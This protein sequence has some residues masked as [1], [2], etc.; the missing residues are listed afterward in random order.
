MPRVVAV[1]TR[2]MMEKH[3]LKVNHVVSVEDAIDILDK[4][5]VEGRIGADIIL[6]DVYLKGGMTG[7]EQAVVGEQVGE[8]V[9]GQWG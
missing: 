8:V 3:G 9:V 6:T 7:G 5:M 1:A 4:A 2:R